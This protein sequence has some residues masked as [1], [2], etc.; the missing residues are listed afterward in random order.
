MLTGIR[1]LI[2]LLL[3][4]LVYGKEIRIISNY[5]LPKNNI[6]EIYEKT[7]DV[8]YII[9]VLEKTEDFEDIRY[10]NGKLFLIKKPTARKIYVYGNKSFWKRE[11]LAISG[12]IEGHTFSK[13]SLKQITTRLKQFYWDRGYPFADIKIETYIE[14]NGDSILKIFIEEGDKAKISEINILSDN[15]IPEALKKKILK[16]L[17]FK[18]G[19]DFSFIKLQRQLE[20]VSK[21]LRKKGYYDNF[22]TFYT[23]RKIKGRYISVDIF[24]SLGF[25]YFISFKGNKSF[26]DDLLKRLLTFDEG[27]NYYQIGKSIDRILEFYKSKG[28]LDVKIT[29]EYKEIFEENKVI[30]SFFIEEG[31][32]Y[33]LKKLDV[34]TDVK[35][36]KDELLSFVNK[37]Y[38]QKGIDNLL[39][40]YFMKYYSKGYLGFAFYTEK[41]ISKKLKTVSLKV[42]AY[43]GKR[44]ILKDIKVFNTGYKFDLSLPT[45][46]RPEEILLYLEEIKEYFKNQGYLDVNVTLDSYFKEDKEIYVYLTIKVE[47]GKRY[48]QGKTFI[49]GTYHLLPSVIE[50]NL[51]KEVYFKK[52]EFDNELDYLY[53]TYLFDTVNPF[54]DTDKRKKIVKKA[55]ILHEDKRG[56]FQ[57]SIGYNTNQKFKLALQGTL[58]NLFNYGFELYG[59]I[60]TSDFGQTYQMSVLNKFVP[61]RNTVSFSIFRNAQ[62]HRIYDLIEKGFQLSVSKRKDKYRTYSIGI[63]YKTN[64]LEKQTFFPETS[65]L[66][67]KFF[68]TYTDLHGIPKDNPFKGY[69]FEYGIY[70]DFGD[71]PIQKILASYR[72][73]YT[74]KFL[75]FAPKVSGGYTVQKLEDIPPSERFFL[76]GIA[77]F[78]GFAY[79]EVA[80][81]NGHG[82]KSFILLNGDIRFPVYRRV[83]LYGFIFYDT[84]N[85]FESFSDMKDFYLRNTAGTGI[86]IPTPAGSFTLYFA[87]NLN[88]KDGES[89]YRIEFSIAT[90]F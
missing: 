39:H 88:K 14:K 63:A 42:Y 68:Y 8:N 16:K 81:K 26:P 6:Q 57:G 70:A 82:G 35:E 58:K 25:K 11:I 74:W 27:I 36:L 2:F 43:K 45:V 44:F 72:Y 78:R 9:S 21:Y 51:S 29:P 62:I 24:F 90:Q 48:K 56:L 47:K 4:S 52:D 34:D 76:G 3:F 79:E 23:L 10:K 87:Y 30:V 77:N 41:E 69:N 89:S 15:P 80:G 28:Y 46:Y 38:N 66:S 17:G 33:I 7:K 86:Y 20:T 64:S 5:P 83:N 37:P 40:R 61:F 12:L 85:V 65:F 19:D 18:K 13:K 32:P 59:Y 55:Y 73:F 84:G 49:Y 54:I 60:E 1:I 75:T 22:A 50:K 53:S 31:K 71:F 67:Y